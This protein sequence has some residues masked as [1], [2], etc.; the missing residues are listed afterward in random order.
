MNRRTVLSLAAATAATQAL[1]RVATAQTSIF[2]SGGLGLPISD[3][4]GRLGPGEAGQTYMSFALTDG[5][6]WVGVAGDNRAVDY[7][8]RNYADPNGVALAD[9]QQEAATL[10]PADARVQETFVANY[11]QILHGSQIDRYQSKTLPAQF[12]GETTRAYSRSV[13]IMYELAPA[14]AAFDYVVTRYFVIAGTKA[15]S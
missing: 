8:E 5:N 15:N 14:P 4:E 10:L 11:A 6:F 13:V 1:P 7:I 9:A 3:W 2:E 12:E